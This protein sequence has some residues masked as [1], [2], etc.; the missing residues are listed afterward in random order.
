MNLKKR[1]S[2]SIALALVGI[3]V[4]TPMLNSV[5]A[6]ETSNQVSKQNQVINIDNEQIIL[7]DAEIK[8][9]N[10]AIE[11]QKAN[12]QVSPRSAL[13]AYITTITIVGIGKVAIYVGGVIITGV[14]AVIGHTLYNKVKSYVEPYM[15]GYSIPNSLRKD[16]N[17]VDVGKF[18]DKV[19]G[20][21]AYRN[22]KTGWTIEKD[23]DGH[24]GSA[25]KVK[26]KSGKRKASIKSNGDIVGK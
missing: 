17:T 5:S 22:P 24:K 7:T 6:M 23:R 4:A 18:T 15:I 14:I 25:W 9:I 26:D 12:P 19:K 13:G 11:E 21:S 20:K 10:K 16:G 8:E 1:I 3:T 2:K